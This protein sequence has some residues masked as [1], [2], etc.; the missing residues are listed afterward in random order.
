MK[1]LYVLDM[2]RYKELKE[3]S[4]SSLTGLERAK[5]LSYY[6]GPM[7]LKLQFIERHRL[8][9]IIEKFLT[10]EINIYQFIAECNG[11]YLDILKL[12]SE[13]NSELNQLTGFQLLNLGT[14]ELKIEANPPEWVRLYDFVEDFFYDI[15]ERIESTGTAIVISEEEEQKFYDSLQKLFNEVEKSEEFSS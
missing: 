4:F 15:E 2:N 7:S 13:L 5:A 11:F 3:K 6:R 10:K 12:V 1:N 9:R 8:F 14:L